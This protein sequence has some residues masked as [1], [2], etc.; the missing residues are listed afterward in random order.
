MA[1]RY[2]GPIMQP[3]VRAASA[4]GICSKRRMSSLKASSELVLPRPLGT[5]RF[6]AAWLVPWRPAFR[7]TAAQS[8]LKFHAHHR[9]ASGRHIAKYGTHEPLVT[10]W[11]AEFLGA[12]PRGIVIDIGA[13]LGWHA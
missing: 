8:K 3:K 10:R 7:T 2:H 6:V 9:D 11:M 1:G 13:N 4:L 5:L 12:A